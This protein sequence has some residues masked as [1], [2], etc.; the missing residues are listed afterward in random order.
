MAGTKVTARDVILEVS[1]GTIPTPAWIEVAGLNSLTHK[2]SENE[3]ATDTTTYDSDGHYEQ[4]VMQRGATLETEG[5]LLKDAATGAL[6]PGQER[7]EELAAAMGTASQG[8]IRFRH[9]MD[10]NWRVWTAT[11]SVGDQGGENNDMTSFAVTFTRSG[12]PS[13]AVVV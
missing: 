11:T 3:E 7:C 12:A 1:D 5:F 2:P 10:T 4:V 6:D 8:E 13:S 9:P